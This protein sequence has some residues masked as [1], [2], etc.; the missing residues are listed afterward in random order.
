PWESPYYTN[1][2]SH[3]KR[4]RKPKDRKCSWYIRPAETFNRVVAIHKLPLHSRFE[5]PLLKHFQNGAI[6]FCPCRKKQKI[7][8]VFFGFGLLLCL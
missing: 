2:T 3:T 1:R 7:L 8:A 5:I 4:V 6:R